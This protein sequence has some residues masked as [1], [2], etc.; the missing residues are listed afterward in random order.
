MRGPEKQDAEQ[1]PHRVASG[2]TERRGQM[3]WKS[4]GNVAAL[5]GVLVAMVVMFNQV[6][7]RLD[8]MQAE[9]NRRFDVLQSE[10]NTLQVEHNRRFDALQTENNRRFDN[11]DR[12]FD[13]LLEALRI[14]E[15]RITR[16]E[17]KVGIGT[18][19]TE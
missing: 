18:N 7:G 2:L 19:A 9:N 1:A 17:E 6:S 13:Q 10:I 4:L 5:V 16:L 15:G 12:R 8:R 3:D 11:M 14:F